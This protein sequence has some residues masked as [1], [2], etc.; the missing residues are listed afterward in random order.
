MARTT[1]RWLLQLGLPLMA[2]AGLLT[3]VVYSGRFLGDRLREQGTLAVAFADIEC[4]PPDGMTRQEFLQEA[5]YLAELPDRLELVESET[6]GRIARALALH[7]WVAKVKQVKLAPQGKV[8]AEL[9]YREPVVAAGRPPRAVDGN[10]VLLPRGANVKGLPTV[11][12]AVAPP[13]GRAGQRWSDVRVRAAAQ[14]VALLRPR[15]NALGLGGCKV[16]VGEGEVTLEGAKCRLIWGRPPDA[17]KP[18]EAS[19]L[20]KLRRLPEVESLA[21]WQWDL[22]PA[23]GVKKQKWQP[24]SGRRP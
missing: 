16:E 24:V 8:T 6:P 1:L 4:A 21:G 19:A 3:G 14:V 2:G 9:M 15:L 12:T 11:S 17:E 22:R 18:G 10:G 13:G 20:V 7:P 5:Q 23:D